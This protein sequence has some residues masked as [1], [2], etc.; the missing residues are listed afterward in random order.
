M[1]GD[2]GEP[3]VTV[4]P[5]P[6]SAS[7][8]SAVLVALGTTV[9]VSVS[10]GPMAE[11]LGRLSALVWALAAAVG[12]VQ[13]LL[14]AELAT[15][16]P[17]RAGGTALYAQEGLGHVSPLLGAASSWGYWLAWAPGIAVN[18]ILAAGYVRATIWPQAGTLWLALIIGALLYG[19]N[20]IGLRPSMRVYLL[21]AVAA[22][23]PI[24]ALFAASVAQPSRL[25]VSRL[26]P[27]TTP[28]GGSLGEP[29]TWA[30]LLK[31][32]FVGAWSAYGAEMASTIAA[33]VQD[34]R[35]GLPRAMAAAGGAGVLAFAIVPATL[36]AAIGADGL[37][38]DPDVAFL[39]AA[40]AVLGSA[41]GTILGLTL[42]AALV[43]GAHTFIV[44]SSRTLYQMALDG[45]LPA[46]LGHVNRF[47]VPVGGVVCDAAV[48]VAMLALFGTRVVDVIAAANVGY[49]IVFVLLPV[50]YV[51]IRARDAGE[52]GAFRLPRS[53]VHV[54]VLLTAFN[55]LLLVG[56]GL[57][58]GVRVLATGAAGMLAI[59][60]ISVLT[61]RRR[62]RL[63]L[64]VAT[65]P[66]DVEPEPVLE[67][68]VA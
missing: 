61:R 50:A 54:A 57:Q 60:P 18:L 22:V 45:H 9:L 2:R 53:F 64:A 19:L 3:A 47:G 31:W 17:H 36:I 39:P 59:V 66:A 41:G 30:L 40:H 55:A 11:Q 34:P 35:R 48:I 52:P 33:E 7:W 58:W 23:V 62:A 16:F 37:A 5:L 63:P 27:L 28:D 42:A 44:G 67:R 4:A 38:A 49:L 24:V 20:A 13:C 12:A 14:I 10:L 46:T 32:T 26:A 1:A 25:D 51:A 21:M 43:L 6:R 29:G 15:R 8:R 56:G 65:A 68:V